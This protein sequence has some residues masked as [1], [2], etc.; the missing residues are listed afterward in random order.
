MNWFYKSAEKNN[1]YVVYWKSLGDTAK[2]VIQLESF[3]PP[4]GWNRFTKFEINPGD[5]VIV[6]NLFGRKKSKPILFKE[7][8]IPV[9]VDFPKVMWAFLNLK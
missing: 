3:S 5:S 6:G 2:V 8:G 7:F 1:I 9:I 4:N